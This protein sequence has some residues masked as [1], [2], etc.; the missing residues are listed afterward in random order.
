MQ[1]NTIAEDMAATGRSAKASVDEI[2]TAARAH[3]RADE[4]KP[5]LL[6]VFS[7]FWLPDLDSNQG[8]AD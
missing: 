6:V 1:E 3:N 7:V 2:V 4:K 5:R 8:P